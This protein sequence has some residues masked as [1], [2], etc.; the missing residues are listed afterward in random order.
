MPLPICD[1]VFLKSFCLL[2]AGT[3]A[4]LKRLGDKSQVFFFE[5]A[6]VKRNLLEHCLHMFVK[7]QFVCFEPDVGDNGKRGDDSTRF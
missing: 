1:I 5:V 3:I 7:R 4:V 2:E 6:L